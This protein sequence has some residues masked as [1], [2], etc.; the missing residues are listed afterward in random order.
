MWVG[1]EVSRLNTHVNMYDEDDE[2]DAERVLVLKDEPRATDASASAFL[3][4]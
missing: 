1:L 4:V 2:D 3:T